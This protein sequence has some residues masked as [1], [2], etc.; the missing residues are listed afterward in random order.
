MNTGSDPTE[1]RLSPGFKLLYGSGNL[2]SSIPLTIIMF[3]QLYFLTDVAGLRPDYAAWSI[4]AGRIWDAVNDPLFGVLSD[5]IRH[6]LGR[7]R[8]LLLT[9][10]LPL[11][12]TFFLMW[13]VPDLPQVWQAV[14][15]ALIFI[16][17]DTCFTAVHVGYNA[18][19]PMLSR[20]YDERSSINGY[21]MIFSM[22]STLIAVI[23]ATL[24]SQ[25]IP[26]PRRVY[27]I[28]GL[29]LGL[30]SAIP[31]FV[32]YAITG[33]YRSTEDPSPLKVRQSILATLS[34]KPFQKVTGL[35]LLSWTAASVVAAV[36]VY[37]AN[38][39]LGV[40]EQANYFVLAAQTA[41]IFFI[42]LVVYLAKK[43]DKK[44]AFLIGVGSWMLFLIALLPLQPDMVPAAY[45]LAGFSGLGI[46]TV[47]VVPWAMLPDII[48]HDQLITGR[49]REGSFYA[50]ISF[51]QKLGT[52]AA[53]WAMGQ[54]LHTAGYV[55]PQAGQPLPVQPDRAVVTIRF[56]ASLV[57][58]GLL[59]I[60]LLFAAGYSIT[61][62]QHQ[63][64]LDRLAELHSS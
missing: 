17:F 52:G 54:L 58:A 28:L 2:T 4:A 63:A 62:E 26:D 23:F 48:E 33:Q 25:V 50:F 46:A 3:F 20:D 47:N 9:G 53:L 42:P 57:P 45:L 49:R 16:F 24:L 6:P 61:R 56:F 19:T 64:T 34:N 31:P 10:S 1:T 12:V 27:V 7:R 30:L 55:T 51:F 32:V 38:Y 13:L 43:L 8:I 36:L 14:Y 40:P 11:G 44:R 29:L 35:Y 18:L 15:Y 60:S 5:R 39:Y 22:G 41:A 21:R 59:L 37:Y